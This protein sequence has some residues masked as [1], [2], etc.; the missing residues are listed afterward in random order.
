MNIYKRFGETK[1]SLRVKGNSYNPLIITPETNEDVI[2]NAR[3]AILN[4][5]RDRITYEYKNGENIIV[6]VAQRLSKKKKK[7]IYTLSAMALGIFTGLLM[8]TFL[9]HETIVSI[10]LA[11]DMIKKV[12]LQLLNMLVAPLTFFSIVSGLSQMSDAKDA[13]RIG[14]RLALITILMMFVMSFLSMVSGIFFFTEDL[15]FMRASMEVESTVSDQKYFSIMNMLSEMFPRNLI[16]PVKENNIMQVMFLS[17]FFGILI[18]KME[19]RPTWINEGISALRRLFTIALEIVVLAIPLVV[20]LSMMSLTSLSR[21]ESIF[22]L[23]KLIVG[24][25]F[26]V[27]LALLVAT[28]M[29]GLIGKISPT[30]FAKKAISFFPIPFAAASSN[31][32]L[33]ATI[34]FATENLGIS[35]KLTSFVVPIGLQFNKQG[36]CF[37]FAMSTAMMMKVYGIEL[38]ADNCITFLIILFLMSITKPSIPCAGIICL[39]YLFSA[40]NIPSEAVMTVLGIEPIMALFIAVCNVVSNTA[41]AF[42]VAKKENMIDLNIYNKIT[43]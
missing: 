15:S 27:I 42:I 8:Q 33:P 35:S 26:G 1:I 10:D 21:P 19:P 12:F 30:N 25:G 34:K 2:K 14:S 36:N 9:L 40:M 7:L 17:I 37:F 39:T 20:F 24:Q 23:G 18:S 38:T 3:L 13:G 31:G 4:A 28:F 6:I 43:S 22:Q 41:V 29:I 16:D 11:T 5:N 32:A